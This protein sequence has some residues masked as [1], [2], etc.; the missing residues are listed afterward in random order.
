MMKSICNYFLKQLFPAL[1]TRLALIIA[2]IAIT[3]ASYSLLLW[4]VQ[5]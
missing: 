1:L 4:G 5:S 2:T 3:L